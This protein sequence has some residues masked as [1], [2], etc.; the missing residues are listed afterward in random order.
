M[1]RKEISSTLKKYSSKYIDEI[2]NYLELTTKSNAITN[3]IDRKFTHMGYRVITHIF[4]TNLIRTGDIDK[5]HYSMQ[6]GYLYYLE[7]LEQT[8]IININNDL[9][10]QSAIMF[11][12]DK[13]IIKYT[14]DNHEQIQ[15]DPSVLSTIPRII[16]L[17][18]SIVWLDNS[19]IEK[20]SIDFNIVKSICELVN[21][22]NDNL[23]SIFVEFGQ[24]RTMTTAEYNE[25]LY[26]TLKIFR[27]NSRHK[28][29]SESEW[30]EQMLTKIPYIEDAK[31]LVI[32]KWCK[33]LWI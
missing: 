17:I 24:K 23:I 32:S 27:D 9:N 20:V 16:K 33:W 7:Y 13:T 15:I 29:Y 12:Y 3:N 2:I 22:S 6:K 30:K 14:Q 31:N 25:F 11:I 21:N 8:E 5:A 19:S 1:N 26:H 4:Q 18:E 28:M 10:N